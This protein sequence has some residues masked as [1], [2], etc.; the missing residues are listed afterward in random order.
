MALVCA[1]VSFD[2]VKAAQTLEYVT[3]ETGDADC[4]H[5]LLATNNLLQN[6]RID[7]RRELS[8]ADHVA[9]QH[10]QLAALPFGRGLRL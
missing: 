4:A 9:E 2:T 8:K 10:G 3:L 5:I 1:R 6:F 7:A